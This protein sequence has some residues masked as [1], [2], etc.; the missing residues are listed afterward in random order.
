[1]MFRKV[2]VLLG[3]LALLF[4]LVTAG[5]TAHAATSSNFDFAALQKTCSIV[6]IHLNGLEHTITCSRT[7]QKGVQPF[8]SRDN[9]CDP[10]Y[11]T[12][13]VYNYGY[14]GVL[15]FDGGG[16]IGV[17]I[18]NVN[19]VDDVANLGSWFRYYNTS[20][21]YYYA[22][23]GGAYKEI[24]FGSTSNVKVTQLCYGNTNYPSC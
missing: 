7:R 22:L 5:G 6:H 1:M 17:A 16:Y 20:G 2:L 3:S 11:D 24:G 21:G 4:T 12:M 23:L 8:I 9:A 14:S 18:Y 19:E 10:S 13:V 15:C